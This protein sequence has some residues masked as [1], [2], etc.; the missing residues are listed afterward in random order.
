M[1]KNIL[2]WVK[3]KLLQCPVLHNSKLTWMII[4]VIKFLFVHKS[5]EHFTWLFAKYLSYRECSHDDKL[6]MLAFLLAEEVDVVIE[7]PHR[8]HS[9]ALLHRF[10]PTS[11]ELWK[12]ERLWHVIMS[13]WCTHAVY[14]TLEDRMHKCHDNLEYQ[15]QIVN[16]VSAW[17]A[18][19]ALY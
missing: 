14:I 17:W 16:C 3:S 10:C 8:W 15:N 19:V 13:Y 2:S 18:K 12:Q 1:E 5:H 6:G 7:S 11:N 9:Q 4:A